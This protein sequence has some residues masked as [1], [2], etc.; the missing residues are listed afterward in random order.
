MVLTLS[1]QDQSSMILLWSSRG[2]I[3]PRKAEG[4]FPSLAQVKLQD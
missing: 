4:D 1:H 3:M 2:G